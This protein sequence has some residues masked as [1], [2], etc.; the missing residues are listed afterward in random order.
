MA[1]DN[2]EGLDTNQE[3]RIEEPEAEKNIDDLRAELDALRKQSEL[4]KLDLSG[5]DKKLTELQKE[6][7]SRMTE[8]EKIRAE[9]A[10]ERQELLNEYANIVCDAISLDEKHRGLIKGN[11]RDEI[12]SSADA[13]KSFKETIIKEYDKKFKELNEELNIL[14]SNGDSPRKGIDAGTKVVTNATFQA[15]DARTQASFINSGGSISG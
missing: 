8:E 12:K 6:I 7:K 1:K 15:M 14:K 4:N 13:V 3:T 5:K 9:A 2:A 11:T 10:Q